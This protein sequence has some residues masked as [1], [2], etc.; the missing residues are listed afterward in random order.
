MTASTDKSFEIPLKSGMRTLFLLLAS[1]VT[2]MVILLHT[3]FV[4]RAQEDD[5]MAVDVAGRQRML[6][7]RHLQEILLVTQ[8]LE[9][10]YLL[11]RRVLTDSL[12]A[13]R[14]GGDVVINL[15]TGDIHPLPPAGNKSIR[16][17]LNEQGVL[18]EQSFRLADHLLATPKDDPDYSLHL[19]ELLALS[20]RTHVAANQSVKLFTLRSAVRS[21]TSI[22]WELAAAALVGLVGIVLGVHLMRT[23]T[24]LREAI[25]RRSWTEELKRSNRDLEHFAGIVSHDLQAPLRTLAGHIREIRDH[26]SEGIE[27][28]ID[29]FTQCFLDQAQDSVERMQALVHGVLE[30]SRVNA[31][32]THFARVD[33]HHIVDGVLADLHDQ[34]AEADA[35]IAVETLPHAWGDKTFIAG[36]FA[37]L[38]GNAIKFR[39]EAAPIITIRGEQRN[40]QC[41][42]SVSDNGIGIETDHGDTVFHMFRRHAAQDRYPGQGIGLAMCKRIVEHHGGI[43]WYDSQAGSGT[44]FHFTLPA[45]RRQAGRA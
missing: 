4:L 21:E 5:A 43:L 7:Q 10:G 8:G 24:A 30:F 22:Y 36:L 34:I 38:V 17:S 33:L 14:D 18:L 41:M 37:N 25:L 20:N 26:G 28:G 15:E 9:A 44:T 13:L 2:I 3:T 40:G 39:G 12:V 45:H 31:D 19:Q 32:M 23:N 6:N 27:G 35:T 42:C 29:E 1:S 16:E 11:T